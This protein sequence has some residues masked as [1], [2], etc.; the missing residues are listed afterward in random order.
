MFGYKFTHNKLKTQNT[1]WIKER[2]LG[3]PE[4]KRLRFNC[5]P[6]SLSISLAPCSCDVK[7]RAFSCFS[8]SLFLP[9]LSLRWRWASLIFYPM[10]KFSVHLTG[11]YPSQRPGS[12]ITPMSLLCFLPPAGDAEMR[13]KDSSVLPT[14]LRKQN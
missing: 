8:R 7:S 3:F 11:P 12:L 1:K 6:S 14:F 10:S 13:T 9:N 5:S 2:A 4:I